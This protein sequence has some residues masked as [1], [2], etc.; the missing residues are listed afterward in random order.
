MLCKNPFMGVGGTVPFGCG[1]CLPCRINRRRQWM[2]R[3]YLESLCHEGNSF[4][5]LT[6]SDNNLPSGANLEQNVV[7][8]FI[9]S[10]RDEIRP[11]RI[12]Y[13][14]VGE[15]GET[16]SRPHYHVS[17]FGMSPFT[18][19][20]GGPRY[21]TLSALVSE[22]WDR[23]F[24]QTAEFNELTAQYISG[25]VV[26][27]LTDY[28]DHR[29]NGKVPEFAR[30]SNRPG[31]GSG[32]MA[33]VAK[34]VSEEF[35]KTGVVPTQLHLGK[36]TVPLGR[37]LL[38]EL[39]RFLDTS[40]SEAKQAF[41][42][43]QSLELRSLLSAALETTPLATSRSVYLESVKQRILQAEARAAIFKKKGTL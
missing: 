27:K 6:Y 39:R 16:T 35:K 25:Y 14:A 8:R 28:R 40:G 24:S 32:A 36:R 15:Y 12:R 31:I 10:L 37:Y 33:L 29:L 1:Q 34:A 2:W 4:L 17:L 43:E 11:R 22:R 5:T 41:M 21:K 38:K 26:K 7:S 42:M 19:V 18:V 20:S 30:M 9:R 13:F 23:G 3:Q